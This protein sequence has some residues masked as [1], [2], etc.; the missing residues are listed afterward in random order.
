MGLKEVK[1]EYYLDIET[2]SLNPEEGKIVTLQYQP[3]DIE[4]NPTGILTI[5]KEWEI[6]EEEIIKRF[7][8]IFKKWEFIPVGMNLSFDFRF[9]LTKIEKYTG[10]QINYGELSNIPHIDIKPILVLM[11]N[12]NFKGAKLSNFT[13]KG[14]NGI[15]IPAYYLNKEYNK[16]TSYIEKEADEFIKFYK[17][18]KSSLVL[19]NKNRKIGE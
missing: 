2:N 6:G 9:L 10:R 15:A 12:G 3:L 11:N 17:D 14:Q 1:M 18:L 16:I 4:G 19:L 7:L 13:S 8:S 5:L